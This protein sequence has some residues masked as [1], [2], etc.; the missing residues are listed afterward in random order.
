MSTHIKEQKPHSAEYFGESRDFWWNADFLELMAKRLHLN[1]ARSVL[2]VGCGIGHWSQILA[3]ILSEHAV[4]TGVDRE[5]LWVEKATKKAQAI[6]VGDRYHYRLGDV[7]ALPFADNTFDLVTCQTVLIH[8]QDP[9]IGLSEMLRVLKPGGTIL[10]AEPNNLSNRTV[11][12]SLTDKFSVDEV[13]DRLK[14]G[15]IIE[16]GKRALGLGFNSLGDLIP[17]YMAELGAKSIKV[18]LSDKAVP[19]FAPYSSKEQQ[20]N[21]QQMKEWAKR[22]FIGWDRCEVLTYFIAGGGQEQEFARYYELLVQD[23][24]AAIKAIDDGT[25]HSAGGMMT[26]LIV[27]HKAE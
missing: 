12:S 20:V 9:R 5:P 13:M 14:F 1:Q 17:G 3:P 7:N 6:G 10:V 19:L 8:L 4:V 27:A 2:D 25:Y 26:Y 15:C 18:Y 21:F 11:F 23:G 16:R 24:E 22:E